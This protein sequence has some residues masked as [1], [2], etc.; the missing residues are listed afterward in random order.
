MDAFIVT[1]QSTAKLRAVTR[2][3]STVHKTD[4]TDGTE[5]GP[6]GEN[7]NL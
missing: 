7:A 5:T 2:R 6:S 3:K 1:I 4:V